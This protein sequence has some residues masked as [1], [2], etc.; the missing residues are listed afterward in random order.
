MKAPGLA[1][2]FEMVAAAVN[3]SIASG[4]MEDSIFGSKLFLAANDPGH[5][6]GHNNALPDVWGSG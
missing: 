1:D 6:D 3:D 4:A 2:P 5:N